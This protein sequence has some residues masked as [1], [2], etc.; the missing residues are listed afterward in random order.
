MHK[1][2]FRMAKVYLESTDTA[3]TI[4]NSNTTVYGA[5]ATKY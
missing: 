5:A 1:R 2:I 4:N 3:F